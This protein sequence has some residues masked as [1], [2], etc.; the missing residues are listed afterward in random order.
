MIDNA[1]RAKAMKVIAHANAHPFDPGVD[2][3]VPGDIPDFAEMFDA[4][5]VVFTFSRVG[6]QLWRHMSVSAPGGLYPS[7]MA[8]F[9]LAELFGF[10]G[11]NQ[12]AIKQM[13]EDWLAIVFDD[14]PHVVLIQEMPN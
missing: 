13:P 3:W 10:T 2:A 6:N 5:R 11:W 1:A 7:L 9:T 4:Y 12:E 14:P 8:I